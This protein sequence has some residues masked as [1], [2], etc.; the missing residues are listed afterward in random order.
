MIDTGRVEGRVEAAVAP[1][2][3][4]AVRPPHADNVERLL[5]RLRVDPVSGLSND[6]VQARLREHGPNRLA[7]PP[8][9]SRRFTRST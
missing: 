7:E 1:P 9:M 6:E 8:R 5:E 4:V 2:D 3:E